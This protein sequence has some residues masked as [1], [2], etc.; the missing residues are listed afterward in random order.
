MVVLLIIELFWIIIKDKESINNKLIRYKILNFL[1]IIIKIA[2]P[3]KYII[4]GTLSVLI[5]IPNPSILMIKVI[6]IILNKFNFFISNN[7]GIDIKANF[8]M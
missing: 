5:N 4:K 6:R 3:N 7:I 8:C 1:L 2:I